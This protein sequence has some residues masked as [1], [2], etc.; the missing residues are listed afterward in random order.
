MYIVTTVMIMENL[1]LEEVTLALQAAITMS[2]A[3]VTFQC[4]DQCTPG[5]SSFIHHI[6]IP[7][8]HLVN[9]EY[10][11]CSTLPSLY[12]SMASSVAGKSPNYSPTSFHLS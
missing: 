7:C 10:R 12:Y 9:T 4:L 5:C 11:H 1:L 2:S 6:V 3:P 8:S